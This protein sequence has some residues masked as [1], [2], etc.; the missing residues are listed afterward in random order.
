MRSNYK[1]LGPFIRVVDIRNKDDHKDNL[2][3]VST[4]KVFIDSV[5]NTVGTDFKKYKIVKKQQFTYVPDTSRRGDKIGI[6]MLESLEQALVSQAYTV[7][8]ITDTNKLDPEY[9]MMWFRRPEF[10]RY[11]RFKSHGSVREIFDWQEM[12]DVELP[13]PSIEKQREIVCEYNVVNDRISLNEQLT[14]KLEDTAQAIYKQWFVNFEFPISKEYAESIGKPEVEGK[15][16]KSSGGMLEFNELLDTEVPIGWSA[17]TLSECTSYL[18]RGIAPKYVEK[19]GCLVLNQKCIRNSAINFELARR[20]DYTNKK[21]LDER[22]LMVNDVVV[23]STGEGTLGRL[24]VVKFLPEKVVVDTHVTI[25][26]PNRELNAHYFWFNLSMREPEF[27]NLAEGST[28]Q[29]ELKREYLSDFKLGKPEIYIQEQFE[30]LVTPI[31]YRLELIE[32]ELPK[33]MELKNVCLQRLARV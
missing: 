1:K 27:V 11:A 29:T 25:L 15:P 4:Q 12:C 24:G 9:L 26:R 18:S 6:A 14:Q 16:Y 31:L 17:V 7:F 19:D 28:G 8:E 2:L 30:K 13:V 23:N 10:D 5:A 32:K 22:Y 21:T 33:L 3:G 20:H